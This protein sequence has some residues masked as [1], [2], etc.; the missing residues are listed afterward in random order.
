MKEINDDFSETY[1]EFVNDGLKDLLDF[2]ISEFKH[3]L[4]NYKGFKLSIVFSKFKDMENFA[5][6]YNISNYMKQQ[7]SAFLDKNTIT[8]LEKNN[9]DTS[10]FI[11]ASLNRKLEQVQSILNKE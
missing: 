10:D 8:A 4:K 3:L 5:K 6:G 9:I 2:R 11:L 7:L 1:K